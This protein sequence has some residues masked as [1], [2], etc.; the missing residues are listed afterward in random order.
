MKTHDALVLV[1]GA[2]YLSAGD[3]ARQYALEP[4]RIVYFGGNITLIAVAWVALVVVVVVQDITVV[5]VPGHHAACRFAWNSE[6][7]QHG[8][9]VRV[10]RNVRQVASDNG[11]KVNV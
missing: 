3:L 4:V 11:V 7:L 10:F 8:E 2:A 9:S 5:P 1:S 6:V